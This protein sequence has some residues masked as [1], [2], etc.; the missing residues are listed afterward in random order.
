MDCM[1]KGTMNCHVSID[2]NELGPAM[3][4]RWHEMK[5]IVNGQ[6]KKRQTISR[7][8]NIERLQKDHE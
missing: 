6:K 7:S 2:V 1:G 4:E 5:T 3:T 8:T